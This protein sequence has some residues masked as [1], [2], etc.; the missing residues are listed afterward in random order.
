MNNLKNLGLIIQLY[1]LDYDEYIPPTRQANVSGAP[2][3]S[4]L[5]IAAGYFRKITGLP[6]GTKPKGDL[7]TLL[8][9]FWPPKQF[10]VGYSAR[11]YGY[12][13]SS[14]FGYG[15]W[16]KISQIKNP[17]DIW[18]I[19]DSID[20]GSSA[21]YQINEIGLSSGNNRIHLRHNRSANFLFVDGS[22]RSFDEEGVKRIAP[23]A[24]Y[25][26]GK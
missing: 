13:R 1:I 3:W 16:V 2:Y 18:I 24:V 20:I 26:T 23:G 17:S 10:T 12:R 4:D 21:R 14:P 8:C 7:N 5:L 22:V 19:A 25:W 15:V 11:I 9:P 6:T